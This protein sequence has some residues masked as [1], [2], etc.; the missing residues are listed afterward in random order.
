MDWEP[1]SEW[2]VSGSAYYKK[3]DGLIS[4]IEGAN[5][6]PNADVLSSSDWD[7]KITR[8]SGLSKGV[9]LLVKKETA[10]HAAWISYTLSK[11]T[12]QFEG[13]NGGAAYP[14]RFDQRHVLHLSYAQMLNKQWAISGSWSYQSGSHISL[15]LNEWQYVQQNGT[16]DFIYQH[17]DNNNNYTLPP[18]HRM[19][20][21]VRYKKKWV[22]GNWSVDLGIYN[23][24]NRRNIYFINADYNP[25]TQ[26]LG[27]T[28]VSLVPVLPY[29][30]LNITI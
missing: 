13:V 3:M 19:D 6:L 22:R 2:S 20:I 4:Y 7:D 28:A 29:F 9:E 16:P 8:G 27:Y 30:S 14:F 17:F 26:T 10:K 23:V 24:Y 11:T 5:F 21:A 15:A 1:T 12:R 25:G 18:Y